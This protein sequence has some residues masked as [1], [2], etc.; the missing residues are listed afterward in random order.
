MKSAGFSLIELLVVML[1]AGILAALAIPRLTDSEINAAGYADQVTASIRYAQRQAVAQH[2][3]VYVC[4][5]AN[6]VKI[7]YDAPCTGA[8]P[9]P[10][11]GAIVQIPQELVAPASVNLAASATPFS[12]NALG[13]PNPIGGVTVTVAGRTVSVTGETG[14]VVRN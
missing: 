13:Q 8:A 1:I 6:S 3:S 9:P 5:T 4:V 10:Q 11:P 7:G 12:F 14:Y 2:R